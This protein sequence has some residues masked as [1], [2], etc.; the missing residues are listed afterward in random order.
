[1]L[2]WPPAPGA[3]RWPV[4]QML[5]DPGELNDWELRLELDLVATERAD[6]PVLRYVGCGPVG[7]AP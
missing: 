3:E 7:T 6:S 4:A 2:A 1:V 5:A